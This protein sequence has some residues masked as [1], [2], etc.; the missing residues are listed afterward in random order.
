MGQILGAYFFLAGIELSIL[1]LISL[2]FLLSRDWRAAALGIGFGILGQ[3]VSL[4]GQA[5]PIGRLGEKFVSLIEVE[6]REAGGAWIRVRG[7]R[8]FSPHSVL[9]PAQT[10]LAEMEIRARETSSNYEILSVERR[11]KARARLFKVKIHHL[12]EC[13]EP[14]VLKRKIVEPQLASERLAAGILWG[15][16]DAI[17]REWWESFNLM[18]ISHLIVVSGSHL[19]LALVVFVFLM[20]CLLRIRIGRAR[21]RLFKVS[22]IFFI[23]STLSV[24]PAEIPLLR[25]MA[26]FCLREVLGYFFPAFYRYGAG[27]WVC[28]IGFLFAIVFPDQIF[29]KSFLFSFSAAWAL[30]APTNRLSELSV[31]K[32]VL[33]SLFVPY[34]GTLWFQG[35]SFFAVLANLIMIPF[36]TLVLIPILVWRE[37]FEWGRAP[38]ESF[39]QQFISF[40]EGIAGFLRLTW[41]PEYVSK[42]TALLFLVGAILILANT[43]LSHFRKSVVL[44]SG[45]LLMLVP[46]RPAPSSPLNKLRIIDVGQGDGLLLSLGSKRIL[47]DGGHSLDQVSKI[48]QDGNPEIDLWV[49][50]HFD[51]DHDEVLLKSAHRFSIGEIWVS[52]FRDPRFKQLKKYVKKARL[53]SARDTQLSKVWGGFVIEGLIPTPSKRGEVENEN[54]LCLLLSSQVAGAGGS[55][56]LR[57]LGLFLGDLDARGEKRLI[58][59][60][61]SR[62]RRERLPILKLSHHGSRF[63]SVEELIAE[64][65]PQ[66]ALVSAGRQN[67]YGHP[68]PSVL[69]RLRRWDAKIMSTTWL[70]D[71]T[72]DLDQAS[73]PHSI[74]KTF[75]NQKM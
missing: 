40:C 4:L 64:V 43:S 21:I 44:A 25:A 51:R 72:L 15:K 46:L 26:A 32:V 45:L 52:D 58:P 48:L 7:Q 9:E 55:I 65:Q 60:L 13:S 5:P 41:T 68:H 33:V 54:S 18:G 19:A 36:F 12:Y 28:L 67:T 74:E 31:W 30:S 6:S 38:I 53:R 42:E 50:S 24:W 23:G 20:K 10:C 22:S 69:D 61:K 57:A 1:I 47:I 17:P 75:S 27:D 70:G 62:L 34:V 2:L 8:I 73:K 29:T 63:S 3:A 59:L 49:L 71:F 11:L 35:I 16:Q 37:L 66:I 56:T 14:V 39:C